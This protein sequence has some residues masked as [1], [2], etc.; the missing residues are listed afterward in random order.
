MKTKTSNIEKGLQS[1]LAILC[2]VF[3]Y[4]IWQETRPLEAPVMTTLENDITTDKD[5]EKIFPG[6]ENNLPAINEFDEM[7]N[8]PLFS[9]NRQPFVAEVIENKKQEPKKPNTRK[10]RE[11]YSLNAVIITPATK[12]AIIQSSKAK[13]LQRIALG[14]TIDN[15][16]LESIEPREIKLSSGTETKTLILEVKNSSPGKTGRETT[17]KNSSLIPPD[18]TFKKIDKEET[19]ETTDK[20]EPPVD[21]KENQKNVKNQDSDEEN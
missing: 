19:T 1:L 5:D 9:E 15:W 10:S 21:T 4:L 16:T 11:E 6:I 17:K 7:V 20:E 14:E 3:I 12:I 8:R 13:E 2:V 18:S